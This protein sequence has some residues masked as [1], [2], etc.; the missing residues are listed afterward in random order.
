MPETS[1]TRTSRTISAPRPVVYRAMTDPAALAIW[2]APEGMRGKVHEFDGRVGGG[3]RMSGAV[4]G[5]YG[6]PG[7]TLVR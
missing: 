6:F 5:V 2:R 7:G 3:Y 1:S 4:E